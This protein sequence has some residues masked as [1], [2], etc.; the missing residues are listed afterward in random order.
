MLMYFS[1]FTVPN[2]T[3]LADIIS[4]QIHQHVVL[5]QLFFVLQKLGPPGLLVLLRRLASADGCPPAGTCCSVPSSSFASV[6]GEAP[7]TSMSSLEK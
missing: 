1:T 4:S 3:D 2:S 7:A 6:S 5:R